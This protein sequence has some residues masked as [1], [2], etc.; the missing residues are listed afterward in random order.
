MTK[1][2]CIIILVNYCQI[3]LDR[4]HTN[5]QFQQ[6]C[7]VSTCFLTPFHI[8]SYNSNILQTWAPVRESTCEI[9]TVCKGLEVYRRLG[10]WEQNKDLIR[11][12]PTFSA[13][14]VTHIHT[15]DLPQHDIIPSSHISTCRQSL[16]FPALCKPGTHISKPFLLKGT[17]AKIVTDLHPSLLEVSIWMFWADLLW[18]AY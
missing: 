3:A 11:D 1:G 14:P 13:S 7:Y 10:S 6:Q 12:M 9:A 18:M 2:I 8:F 5:F 15:T 4:D 17:R 16:G